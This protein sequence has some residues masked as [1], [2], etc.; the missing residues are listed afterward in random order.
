MRTIGAIGLLTLGVWATMLH[1]QVPRGE[2]VEG[3]MMYTVLSY[4]A[5]PSIDSPRFV[6]AERADRFMDADELI[7]GLDW[8][9]VVKA[10][11]TWHLD[12]HEIVNDFA[13]DTPIAVTW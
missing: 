7:L 10:Y 11:S 1:A 6:P 13:G 4:D 5:I 9:G 2:E 12:Q 3:A 8:N